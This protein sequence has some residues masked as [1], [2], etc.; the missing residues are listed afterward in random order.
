MF[1]LTLGIIISSVGGFL[2]SRYIATHKFSQDHMVCPL[3]QNCGPL[4]TGRFSRFLGMPVEA[5]GS[6]YYLVMSLLYFIS[7][8]RELP[9]VVLAGGV[10][11][12][13]LAFAFS[14]YL[15]VV[16]VFAIKKWCTISL[17]SA[18]ISFLILVLVF[19]GFEYNFAE[20]AYTYRDLLKWIYMIGLI[21]GAVITTL[22]AHTFIK[23]LKDF[24][25]TRKEERRLEMFSHTAWV[26]LG[27]SFLAGLGLAMTDRWAEY[28]D[29]TKFIVIIIVFAMLIIYETIVNLLISPKLIGMHFGDEPQLD[30]HKHSMHRKLSFGFIGVG[31]VSWYTLLLLSVFNWFE[32]SSGQILLGYGVLLVLA[33]ALVMLVETIIYNKSLRKK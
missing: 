25:I 29:S 31:V 17:G 1:W 6:A 10:L 9:T 22:H 33:V 26:A 5:I 12:A 3:G 19:L 16:Q 20:F 21:I 2:L 11:L 18:A 8:F 15:V 24:T 13:G 27:F 23:F 30:D 4:V 7:L 14:L 32:Y 28:V